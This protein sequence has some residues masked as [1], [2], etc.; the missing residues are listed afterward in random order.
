LV[1][2][3]GVVGL[4]KYNLEKKINN[5]PKARKK[6]VKVA[7]S[8]EGEAEPEVNEVSPLIESLNLE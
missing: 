8:G 3:L 1:S 7:E 6:T 4:D 2:S 5:P